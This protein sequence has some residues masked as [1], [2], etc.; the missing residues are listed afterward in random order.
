V[1]SVRDLHDE[2]SDR[3]AILCNLLDSQAGKSGI[4]ESLRVVLR[5]LRM[6]LANL[7]DLL[8][9]QIPVDS[10]APSRIFSIEIRSQI[11]VVKAK[12]PH[13]GETMDEGLSQLI[14]E[15]VAE[16]NFP[17][18]FLNIGNSTAIKTIKIGEL[19]RRERE[20]LQI[21]PRGLTSKAMASE[22]FLTEATIKSHISAIYRKFEV[23]NRTQAIVVAL[24]NKL[25]AF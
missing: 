18:Y 7:A 22:L 16:L 13:L 5:E 23:V 12:V 21:L 9:A 10:K 25:L 19:T 14:S 3:L 24:D 2:L 8:N 20:I 6:D 4:E 11:S 15:I 17:Q 1:R